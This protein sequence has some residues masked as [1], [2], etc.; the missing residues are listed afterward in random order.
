MLSATYRYALIV[1]AL[2]ARI[3]RGFGLIL[4]FWNLLLRTPVSPEGDV[5]FTSVDL[6]DWADWFWE[7]VN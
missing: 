3:E 7:S 2:R 5:V 4:E 1:E 6:A